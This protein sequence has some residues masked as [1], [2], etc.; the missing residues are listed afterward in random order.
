MTEVI[1]N[2]SRSTNTLVKPYRRA[3]KLKNL[4][5]GI[6]VPVVSA[7]LTACGSPSSEVLSAPA[8][9]VESPDSLNP[10]DV[11]ILNQFINDNLF[12]RS[13]EVVDMLDTT[14]PG[15]DLKYAGSREI[16]YI[17]SIQDPTIREMAM[18]SFLSVES[19][20]AF[21][22]NR[23]DGLYTCNYYAL[24]YLRGLLGNEV[25]GSNYSSIAG[26][27]GVPGVAGK[28]F[29]SGLT[30]EEYNNYMANHPFLDSNN[31]DWWMSNYGVNYGWHNA[32]TQA[33]LKKML[34]VNGGAIGLAVSSQEY[35]AQERA[36]KE[37]ANDPVP[38]TGHALIVGKIPGEQYFIT[39]S[40]NN[41]ALAAYPENSPYEKVNPDAPEHK[42]SFWVHDLPAPVPADMP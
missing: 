28:D 30:T 8:A 31:L 10:V 2:T 29:I 22:S 17:R 1:K 21:D 18:I 40:T 13:P 16:A 32:T 19:S 27:E 24:S 34:E 25:I 7:A 4:V 38:F 23:N 42:Y 26:E 15:I 14:Y 9:Q 12:L 5:F 35:I 36:K 11:P 3:I 6:G 41:I 37:A 39:Q 20:K 33:E